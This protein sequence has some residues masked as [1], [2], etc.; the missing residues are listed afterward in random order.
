M[1]LEFL[2]PSLLKLL[3]M[4]RRQSVRREVRLDSTAS[5]LTAPTIPNIKEVVL[6]SPRKVNMN[7]ITD[8]IKL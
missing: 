2:V 5:N 7:T 3:T 1:K 4:Q 6:A 8:L